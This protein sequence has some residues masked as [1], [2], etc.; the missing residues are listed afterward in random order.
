[1]QAVRNEVDLTNALMTG[2]GLRALGKAAVV[3]YDLVTAAKGRRKM[4]GLGSEEC[5]RSQ[6]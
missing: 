2:P 3:R 4:N 6:T 1:M 5:L